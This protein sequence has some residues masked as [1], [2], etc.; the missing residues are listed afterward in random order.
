M[1]MPPA[2]SS[3]AA[4]PTP[5]EETA[6]KNKAGKSS[7]DPTA[8]GR[9]RSV[10][11]QD[12]NVQLMLRFQKGDAAAFEELVRRNTS[13]IHGLVYRFLGDADQVEDITQDV[14]LRVYRNAPRYKPTAKFTTWLY[15]IVANLCFNVIRS[16]RR[17]QVVALESG[18]G[19]DGESYYRDV[20]DDR[21]PPPQKGYDDEELRRHIAG[22][23]ARLPDN[24]RLAILLSKYEHKSYDEI[25]AVLN[26]STMAVK[27][28]LSR[29]RATLRQALSRSMRRD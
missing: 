5:P 8:G 18:G 3:A 9:R 12:E 28:L 21:N 11:T 17:H 6:I 4:R 26:C 13:K 22:A 23:V 2:G 15:R 27:S 29:A 7:Q 1:P 16:R 24:Q 14:F 20:P 10:Y 19:E 25:A